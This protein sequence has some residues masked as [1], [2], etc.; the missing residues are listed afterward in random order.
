MWKW[1]LQ[2]H[3]TR[4]YTD[5]GTGLPILYREIDSWARMLQLRPHPWEIELIVRLDQTFRNG[6]LR[7]DDG[8]KVSMSDGKGIS[9]LM[10]GFKGRKV[11]QS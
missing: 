2:L 5:K 7:S 1:F 8:S 6:T 11:K 3:R 4:T 10:R 9:A